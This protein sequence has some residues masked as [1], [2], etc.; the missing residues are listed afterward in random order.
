MTQQTQT[1]YPRTP[2]W[3]NSPSQPHPHQTIQDTS[4]IV[5]QPII[6]T[7]KIDGTNTLLHRGKVYSRS[8]PPETPAPWQSLLRKHHAWKLRNSSWL[9]YGENI[10]A[11]HSIQY[12]PVP[13]QNT[14]MAFALVDP[15]GMFTPFTVLQQLCRKLEIPTV[16][17]LFRGTF[18]SHQELDH[19]LQINHPARSRLG[20]TMEGMVIRTAEGFHQRQFQLHVCKS[21]RPDHAGNQ[22]HWTTGWQQCPLLTTQA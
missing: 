18:K 13:E 20:R 8:S 19:W 3:P 6:I 22:D 10:Q 15:N 21:V 14:F 17:V 7:E 4:L 1:K 16:P 5:G 12:D 9:L 11:I 2:Y